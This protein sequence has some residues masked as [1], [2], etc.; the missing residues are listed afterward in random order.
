MKDKLRALAG[1]LLALAMLTLALYLLHRELAHHHWS[2]MVSSFR[3]IP[4]SRLVWA[5][6][7]TSVSYVVLPGYDLL[8]TR[9]LRRPLPL[10]RVAL[11]GVIGY[12]ATHNFGTLLGGTPVRYR[13]YSAWGFSAVE[14]AK[15]IVVAGIAFWMGLCALTGVVFLLRPLPAPPALH[16]PFATVRPLSAVLLALTLGYVA[17]SAMPRAS[18]TE[19]SWTLRPPGVGFALA[20]IGVGA[21]DLVVASSVLYV[22]LPAKIAPAFP[23]FL[24]VYL[25][26]IFL[27]ASTQVPGGIG[28]FEATVLALLGSNDKVA[29]VGPLL[30]FR[31]IYY[32]LPMAAAAVL[33]GTVEA[34][35]LRRHATRA[36]TQFGA[37]MPAV[38]PQLLALSVFV[39]G[40]VLLASGATPAEH[41]RLSLLRPVIPLPIVEASHFLGS[42]AGVVLLV[43]AHALLRRI[44]AAWLL[45]A[46]LL[47]IG[48]VLSLLKGFD[49]E[50]AAF[51]AL[52]LA[53]LLPCRAE[54]YRQ[55][56]L[57]SRRF[58]LGWTTTLV[59]VL[60]CVA[61]LTMFSHRHIEYRHELWWTF[62]LHAEA[63]RSLRALVGAAVG[64]LAFG[65]ARLLQPAAAPPSLPTADE[66]DAAARVVAQSRATTAAL[67]LLGDKRLLFNAP[68]TA[69]IMFGVEG[70]SWVAMGDP[71]GPENEARDL[72]WRFRE[73]CDECGA[74]PV[75]YE[76]DA[77]QLP[78]YIDLG[79]SLIKIGEE[80]HVPLGDFNLEGGPRKNLRRANKHALESGC[81]FEV[82][83]RP[84]ATAALPELRAISDAWLSGKHAAEKGFSLGYF[85]V[86]YLQRFPVAAVRWEGHLVA[87]ANLLTGAG[88]EELSVDLMRYDPQAPDEV[89]EFL[90]VQSMLWG[91][92][93]GYARFNLGM[94]PLAGIEGERLGPL[95]N[96]VAH[97]A[98]MHGEHFYNFQGLRQYKAKFGPVWRPKYL[99]SPGGVALP[100]ILANVATLISGGLRRLV[101]K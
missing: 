62:E 58:T 36:V 6:G 82:L 72:A 37:W 14:I 46:W 63:P 29:V 32:L 76:V 7:L 81:Q 3:S 73:L 50:E 84:Q 80:A 15:L 30:A 44:D 78:L 17:W 74:W 8:A 96:R 101:A 53:A 98:Y 67:A 13:L 18:R 68:R 97:L 19:K 39:A 57:L 65:V 61:W 55:G 35:A 47:V 86:E 75:F 11:V 20:Q 95:W 22:L 70:K 91:K 48:I 23:H 83:P 2:E 66:L 69:F 90:F 24:G 40:A 87:F 43:L 100:A 88:Q 34:A 31:V 71:V 85:D 12:A 4:S 25:L 38:A 49:Y 45:A 26:A 42:V 21:L 51:L 77:D 5:L 10:G 28:V 1:P 54:F 33:L 79:L 52:M 60:A 89:M 59:L 41:G 56:A 99:A 92:E 9:F 94:A 27:V 64:A 16:L 93:H